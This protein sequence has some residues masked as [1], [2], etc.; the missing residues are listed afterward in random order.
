MEF[1]PGAVSG[2]SLAEWRNGGTDATA[3]D[4]LALLAVTLSAASNCPA[5]QKVQRIILVV[6]E[7][8]RGMPQL[9]SEKVKGVT[10]R[11]LHRWSSAGNRDCLL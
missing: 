4:P 10:E 2:Y 9:A 5:A 11:S 3:E 8:L 7:L 6:N 1:V